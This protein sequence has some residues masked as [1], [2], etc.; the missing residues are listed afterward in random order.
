MRWRLASDDELAALTR[1]AS[2]P[3]EVKDLASLFRAALQHG[4]DIHPLPNPSPDI[5][6]HLDEDAVRSQFPK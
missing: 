4:R 5:F 6:V 1:S 3:N 2:E